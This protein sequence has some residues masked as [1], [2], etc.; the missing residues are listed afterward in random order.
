MN[1]LVTKIDLLYRVAH[2]FADLSWVDLYFE[3]FTVC[4]NLPGLMGIRQKGLAMCARWWNTEIQVISTQV[5]DQ[6]GHPVRK[7]ELLL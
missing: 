4:P 7:I 2:L 6:M 5:R 1:V 3:C